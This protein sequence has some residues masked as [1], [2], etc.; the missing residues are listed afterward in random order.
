MPKHP[1]YGQCGYACEVR[2][3]ELMQSDETREQQ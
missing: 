3:A 1:F 2:E